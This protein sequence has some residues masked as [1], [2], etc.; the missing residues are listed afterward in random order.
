[1]EGV[2]PCDALEA[3]HQRDVL[4]WLAG[5]DGIVRIAKPATP[6][7][8]LVSYCALVDCDAEQILLVHHRDA[9]RWLPTGGHVRVDEH[10]ADAATREIHEELH[11]R[12]GFHDAVGPTPLMVTVTRTAGR[13]EPHIDVSLW[14][15]FAGSHR[16]A[17]TPDETE[18][19]DARWWS[20][21]EVR[22]GGLVPFDPHLPR[23]IGKLRRSLR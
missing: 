13:S 22:S 14:F 11:I 23:F 4:T 17:L 10:P 18:F 2:E 12:P 7:K 1:M 21:G 5:T 8:H 6:P 19:S 15:V 9:E 20:F 16:G 3:E